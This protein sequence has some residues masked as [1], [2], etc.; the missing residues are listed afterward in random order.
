M[1]KQT[2]KLAT[3][4]FADIVG[5][6]AMMQHDE[7]IAL[8]KI[9]HFKDELRQKVQEFQGEIIQYYG[10]GCLAIFNNA[11]DAMNCAVDLQFI[12]RKNL[13][14][15]VR[16]GVHLGEILVE[17]ENI[18]GDS[19]NITSRIQGMGVPGSV[20]LSHAVKDQIRN[21][22]NFQLKSLGR[23]EFKNVDEPMEVFALANG[24]MPVPANEEEKPIG[25]NNRNQGKN[26]LATVSLKARRRPIIFFALSLLVILTF[27]IGYATSRKSL[28]LAS[29]E[30]ATPSN[31]DSNKSIAVLAFSDMSANHDQ[32]YLSDGIAEEIINSLCKFS[33]LKV[34]ARTS[35]F[36]FKNKND[37]I[38][39]IGDKLQVRNILE[40]SVR[41][42]EDNILITVRLTNSENGFTIMSESYTDDFQNVTALQSSIAVDIAEKIGTRF[43]LKERQLLNRN[44]VNPLAFE[45]Y[46]K[47]RSQFVNGPLNMLSGEI[48]DA[49]KYFES[50]IKLDTTFTDAYAYLSLAYFN[51]TDWALP[52]TEVVAIAHALDSAKYLAKRAHALDSL[53]SAAHLAMGSY[54]FHQL[55]WL[56]AENE[57]RKAVEL[58]PGG[59][60]EKFILASFL[61]QFGQADEALQLDEEA[62]KLD[63]LDP[64]SKI[65]YAR[66][67]YRARKFDECI[68]L[69]QQVLDEKPNSGGAYQFL[70]M[71]YLGNGQLDQARKAYARLQE[72]TGDNRCAEIY[73]TYDFQTATRKM[74]SYIQEEIPIEFQP[75]VDLAFYS[76]WIKDKDNVIKY[77]NRSLDKR[78][79][80]ISFLSQPEFDFIRNDPRC[81]E[82]YERAGFKAYYEYKRKE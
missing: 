65:K 35:S 32:E 7:E 55:E 15:P 74:I 4:M 1:P 66:D 2:R 64:N 37:D 73:L 59:A 12:F 42:N 36:S 60:E 63:P 26:V 68:R 57:K 80:Q 38:R 50:A 39:T 77:L 22:P 40:G 3:I 54:Y 25:Q 6:T 10:D 17:E 82:F 79:P 67:L 75:L 69:C 31:P 46:L 56:E 41:K 24:D 23:F 53:N 30:N 5:Y 8:D 19:V 62:I 13:Q 29:K 9:R 49:K 72:L 14:I 81:L 20:L 78:L 18:F 61:G 70:S 16:I 34:A 45:T 11:V 51:L 28:R 48:F 27:L 44:K 21:K 58:N 52:R 47:G 71:S 43:S 76:A 33:E